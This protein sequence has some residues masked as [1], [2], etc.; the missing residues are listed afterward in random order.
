MI[1]KKKRHYCKYRKW[2]KNHKCKQILEQ[3]RFLIE[4]KN[5]VS[6]S[7]IFPEIE[8]IIKPYLNVLGI[9]NLE[10]AQGMVG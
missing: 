4:D 10:N 2:Q 1:L 8:K 6:I 9:H 5:F 7:I 3:I